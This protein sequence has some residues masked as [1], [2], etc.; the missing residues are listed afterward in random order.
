VPFQS[1]QIVSAVIL[2]IGAAQ[3]ALVATPNSAIKSKTQNQ[4]ILPNQPIIT[5]LNSSFTITATGR[6]M[7]PDYFRSASGNGAEYEFVRYLFGTIPAGTLSRGNYHDL[8]AGDL[9]VV[10]NIFTG[11][12]NYNTVEI[13]FAGVTI[14]S[15][16]V[17]TVGAPSNIVNYLNYGVLVEPFKL[18]KRTA[19]IFV[20]SSVDLSFDPSNKQAFNQ[21]VGPSSTPNIET[22]DGESVP[23]YEAPELELISSAALGTPVDLFASGGKVS[24]IVNS[25]RTG[26]NSVTAFTGD[27]IGLEWELSNYHEANI[28]VWQI[29]QDPSDLS[30]VY[31][32][33]GKWDVVHRELEP[34][35]INLEQGAGR[36]VKSVSVIYAGAGY[37]R[38]N[39][40]VVFSDPPAGGQRAEGFAVLTDPPPD[41]T[42]EIIQ[43]ILNSGG[44]GY[45]IAPTVTVIGAN[46]APAVLEASL[47]DSVL[48][49][50]TELRIPLVADVA[51]KDTFVVQE[52]EAEKLPEADGFRGNLVTIVTGVATFISTLTSPF[53]PNLEFNYITTPQ[54][55]YSKSQPQSFITKDF[56]YDKGFPATLVTTLTTESTLV[57]YNHFI[58]S[59]SYGPIMKFSYL[60]DKLMNVANVDPAQTT[61]IAPLPN[62]DINKPANE[63]YSRYT[64]GIFNI[65]LSSVKGSSGI[66]ERLSSVFSGRYASF[67][68]KPA[69]DFSASGSIPLIGGASSQLLKSLTGFSKVVQITLLEYQASQSVLLPQRLLD[70]FELNNEFSRITHLL[71]T[72]STPAIFY[73]TVL[74][75][76]GSQAEYMT[77]AEL[78]GIKSLPETVF[79]NFSFGK[80]NFD[81]TIIT[82]FT[83]AMPDP[84]QTVIEVWEQDMPDA[85]KVLLS[86]P[87]PA[88]LNPEYLKGTS[89]IEQTL[90]SEY[91]SFKSF[92][93]SVTAQY[94]TINTIGMQ[95]MGSR[96]SIESG[97]VSL[98]GY[99]YSPE[100][101]ELPITPEWVYQD[102]L[103]LDISPEWVYQDKLFLD[104]SPE[105]VYQ[106]KLFLDIS[107]EWLYQDKLFLDISP[108][109]LY[110][111][112]LFLDISPEWLYQDKLFTPLDPEQAV[113]GDR[114]IDF[115]PELLDS[116]SRLNDFNPELL[117]SGSRLI[118]FNAYLDQPILELRGLESD[119]IESD[120]RIINFDP[121]LG[122]SGNRNIDF[123]PYNPAETYLLN[124][125]DLELLYNQQA[126]KTLSPEPLRQTKI[127]FNLDL[128][129]FQLDV[130]Y[131]QDASVYGAFKTEFSIYADD[132][133]A[134]D[135]GQYK[136]SAPGTPGRPRG[137]FIAYKEFMGSALVMKTPTYGLGGFTT[138]AAAQTQADK[139]VDARPFKAILSDVWNYRI[140]F[141]KKVFYPR[142]SRIFP[143]IWYIR[144]G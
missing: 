78:P 11:Y 30:N 124:D 122:D 16:K 127:Y 107:P 18:L 38:N 45:T 7:V 114:Y 112:K 126:L 71:G 66:K 92:S 59:L 10:N 20:T 49:R 64:E 24:F 58:G 120:I 31:T 141:A 36:S 32:E 57:S 48:A 93:L 109:W 41:G 23:E 70:G 105:W 53:K 63:F 54:P 134:G 29:T 72:S 129:F 94:A 26:A 62:Y 3:F 125:I 27:K 110:Q 81:S 103:F 43:I 39:I 121:M 91:F 100:V 12:R 6:Y 56:I 143:R 96:L 37:N 119:F 44:S 132:G 116:G 82:L 80:N 90:T 104:I 84:K 15:F 50:E 138:Q 14:E 2:S 55:L 142:K 5:N 101:A 42:G 67:I 102:K 21:L 83:E 61:L 74:T 60:F 118:E 28:T 68:S 73:T 34:L 136:G 13:I 17:K 25:T 135:L 130:R 131:L 99:Y 98:D 33:V 22:F 51:L 1:S 46:T 79:I 86:I 40:D 88:K 8:T 65:N 69:T 35:L 137:P 77:V 113:P 140:Y 9:I 52:L 133:R 47:V 76:Q 97:N 108:E 4:V 87:D 85:E 139:Y 123:P 95:L 128:T 89:S 115:N 19:N 106:D 75:P 111:D 144:G 117:D